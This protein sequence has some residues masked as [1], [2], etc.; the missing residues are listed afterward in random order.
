MV[1]GELP[2]G[3]TLN[4]GEVLLLFKH[5]I[6]EGDLARADLWSSYL[7]RANDG[8]EPVDVALVEALARRFADAI[9]TGEPDLAEAWADAWFA[10]HGIGPRTVE[11]PDERED[12]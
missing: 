5:A 9:N 3:P 7:L 8:R 2:R 10:K 12:A 11:A 6:G 1:N 4:A